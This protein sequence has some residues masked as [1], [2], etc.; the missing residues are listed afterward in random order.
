MIT[1]IR[2]SLPAARLEGGMKKM[3]L[4]STLQRFAKGLG[5]AAVLSV[6]AVGAAAQAQ[7]F[8]IVV[9]EWI[10]D[11]TGEQ[12]ISWTQ[13]GAVTL[14]QLQPHFIEIE[15]SV[16]STSH[17]AAIHTNNLL[18]A[19]VN[20]FTGQL[21]LFCDITIAFGDVLDDGGHV[22]VDPAAPRPL[23]QF[24]P[25]FGNSGSNGFLGTIYTSPEASGIWEMRVTGVGPAG[26]VVAP[27]EST[28]FVRV[29]GLPELLPGA[30]YDLVGQTAI[31]PNNH[32]GTPQ[33]NGKLVKVA[34]LYVAA[35]PGNKLRYNDISLPLGGVFDISATW[36]PLH[37]SHR[38]G[39]DIDIG[40]VPA[41]QTRSLT[42]FIKAAGIRTR[43]VEGNHWH[44][45]E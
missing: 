21:I 15:P 12:Q 31:H 32:F 23:G 10:V 7:D 28:I 40:L 9:G 39:E 30:N 42:R 17:R 1:C 6:A 20:R 22:H 19:C 36:L 44:L 3:W 37:A 13:P 34:N 16:T 26:E 29:P 8:Q 43:K 27:F 38:F 33:F 35:F 11:E 24:D 4:V 45:R 18:F 14:E 25:A 41:S 2:W 5:C